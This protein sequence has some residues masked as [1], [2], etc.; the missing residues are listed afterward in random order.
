M[1]TGIAGFVVPT[2]FS[3]FPTFVKYTP[4]IAHFLHTHT[5]TYAN[6][7]AHIDVKKTKLGTN[8]PNVKKVIH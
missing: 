5:E 4:F 8:I 6:V 7:N 2:R 1:P 3:F